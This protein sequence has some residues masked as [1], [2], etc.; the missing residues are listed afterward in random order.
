MAAVY[1]ATRGI[2]PDDI[3]RYDLTAQGMVRAWDSRYHGDYE[4]CESLWL[5]AT[6][7]RIVTACGNVFHTAPERQE[8][9]LFAGAL[10]LELG[11][12]LPQMEG[13]AHSK[14]AGVL[15]ALQTVPDPE[16]VTDGSQLDLELRLYGY[17]KLELRERRPLPCLQPESGRLPTHGRFVF[18]MNH[19]G[20][21]LLLL[22]RR[23]PRSSAPWAAALT[24]L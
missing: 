16:R 13:V 23:G 14:P 21:A 24:P 5:D 2:S 1:A 19:G 6:G 4:M 22:Q 12:W 8:D 3:E 15:L 11:H 7:E 17:E 9:M 20:E 18:S 10:E